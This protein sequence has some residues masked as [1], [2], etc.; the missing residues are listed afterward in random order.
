[1]GTKV[2]KKEKS[3]DNKTRARPPS[4]LFLGTLEPLWGC[5]AKIV[6]SMY[7][8]ASREVSLRSCEMVIQWS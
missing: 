6:R 1:M 8:G 7:P 5:R 3:R 2:N 4:I